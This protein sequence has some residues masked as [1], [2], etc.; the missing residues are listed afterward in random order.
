MLD[1]EFPNR[2]RITAQGCQ[3]Q[4][5][6]PLNSKRAIYRCDGR[7]TNILTR[8]SSFRPLG[9]QYASTCHGRLA[10][11]DTTGDGGDERLQR[12]HACSQRRK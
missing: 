1:A 7:F 11:D 8:L 3:N 4:M 6:R 5:T 10:Q 9:N 2:H 12:G